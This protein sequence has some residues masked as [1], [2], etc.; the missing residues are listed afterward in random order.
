MILN[1]NRHKC[2]ATPVSFFLHY[3]GTPINNEHREIDMLTTKRH[4]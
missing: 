4:Y 2:W 3:L 1:Q